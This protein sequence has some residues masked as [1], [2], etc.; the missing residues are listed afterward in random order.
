MGF[1]CKFAEFVRHCYTNGY[2]KN[3]EPQTCYIQLS[4]AAGH[5]GVSFCLPH[6]IMPKLPEQL[7]QLGLLQPAKS[8][9]HLPS[10]ALVVRLLQ[11]VDSVICRRLCREHAKGCRHFSI[12]GLK[13]LHTILR[14]LRVCCEYSQFCDAAG[15]AVWLLQPVRSLG[16]CSLSFSAVAAW[17]VAPW[18]DRTDEAYIPRVYH[19][20][21]SHVPAKFTAN[22]TAKYN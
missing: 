8:M 7:L 19:W 17:A 14:L 11:P 12:L 9:F 5:A 21:E 15:H 2:T 3:L 22:L 18:A 10:G 20:P 4:A 13:W 1:T 16:C 6:Q